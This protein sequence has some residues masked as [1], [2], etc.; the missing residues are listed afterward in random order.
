VRDDA[1]T[2]HMS[3]ARCLATCIM[4]GCLILASSICLVDT[5]NAYSWERAQPLRVSARGGTVI[6]LTGNFNASAAYA[7]QFVSTSPS[8]LGAMF[9]VIARPV[10]GSQLQCEAPTWTFGAGETRLSVF[11]A[12]GEAGA[13]AAN[14]REL[15]PG[16]G[17]TADRITYV[18]VW[19]ARSVS[20]GEAEGG[21]S[22]AIDG[23]GFNIND[24]DYVCKFVC[25]HSSCQ[26]LPTQ[27]FA[28]SKVPTRPINDKRLSCVS[29]RW[30]FTAFMDANTTDAEGSTKIV[31]E[32][33]GVELAYVGSAAEGQGFVFE[34][35]VT[36]A[37]KV[38]GLATAAST[39]INV[40][41]FG[42]DVQA[43][44]YSCQ[45]AYTDLTPY[46]Y[47]ASAA[48]VVTSEVMQCYSPHWIT[49]AT[50]TKIEIFKQSCRGAR[51]SSAD[52]P[53]DPNRQVR[54][55]AGLLRFAFIAA[56][57]NLS[58]ASVPAGFD[59]SPFSIF[60][61]GGGFTPLA[62]GYSVAFTPAGVADAPPIIELNVTRS[63]VTGTS[64]PAHTPPSRA[65][66]CVASAC[67]FVCIIKQTI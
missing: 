21:V 29:P 42:F 36:N 1:R 50:T 52:T 41:G 37:D 31:L 49:K 53:C 13:V 25:I 38:E 57:H 27:R 8:S 26:S 6:S 34:D 4:R 60:I 62:S 45:F 5:S 59:A 15:L 19:Q 64:R 11:T 33:G 20:S 23:Y 44:D 48:T 35:T 24:A 56:V 14:V 2:A 7:C 67:C 18:A 61:N 12:I 66:S 39:L 40:Y 17:E 65:V 30:P 47:A 55:K 46:V 22:I 54:R 10:D 51:A 32:K 43:Q 28:Q 3:S 63:S 9:S 58:V 16:P